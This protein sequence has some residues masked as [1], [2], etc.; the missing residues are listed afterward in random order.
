MNLTPDEIMQLFF[1]IFILAS[2]ISYLI[3]EGDN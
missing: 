3:F 1:S 2:F